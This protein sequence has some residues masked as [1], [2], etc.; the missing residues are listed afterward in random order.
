MADSIG[1]NH[2][3]SSPIVINNLSSTAPKAIAVTCK[4]CHA[5]ALT[6]EDAAGNKLILDCKKESL[7]SINGII[8]NAGDSL[9]TKEQ[10]AKFIVIENVSLE[11]K[12]KDSLFETG[13]VIPDIS[14]KT[15]LTIIGCTT[16]I[17]HPSIKNNRLVLPDKMLYMRTYNMY[18]EEGSW[19]AMELPLSLKYYI[20]GTFDNCDAIT[21]IVIPENIRIFSFPNGLKNLERITVK[22]KNLYY[23]G[24]FDSCKITSYVI[25]DGC[26]EVGEFDLNETLKSIELPASVKIIA[27]Q[28]FERCVSLESVKINGSLKS[29]GDDAFR[30][31]TSLKSFTVPTTESIGNGVFDGCT[32]LEYVEFGENIER[33]GGSMFNGCSALKKVV[34][35]DGMK[36]VMPRAFQYC[37]ALEE[38]VL[39]DSITYIGDWAFIGC[40]SLK[41]VSYPASITE[42]GDGVFQ[43]C[44]SLKIDEV[45]ISEK[46]TKIGHSVFDGVSV[47][48]MVINCEPD[49]FALF[50]SGCT[51]N[52]LI[53]DVPGVSV[54]FHGA[55]KCKVNTVTYTDGTYWT[56]PILAN[57]INIMSKDLSPFYNPHVV[58]DVRGSGKTIN[59]AGSAENWN[60]FSRFKTDDTVKV[61]FNVKFN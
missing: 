19:T 58:Y 15:G 36:Q 34:V 48:L 27:K 8:K 1:I 5:T 33:I 18:R 12:N 20:G 41:S 55:T 21:E 53:V 7:D 28:A 46:I 39:P 60:E 25:P 9:F 57:E 45:V 30:N 32:S 54:D 37:A 29:I 44:V 52:T 51:V 11:V 23:F 16:N 50:L 40:G 42:L 10:I 2:A 4:N 22:A 26:Y 31:C 3:Y 14:A 13:V 47:D 17:A 49:R 43:N 61:N 59:F 24:G 38:V 35:K 6:L 56:Y